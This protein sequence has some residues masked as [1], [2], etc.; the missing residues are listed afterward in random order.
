MQRTNKRHLVCLPIL[1]WD[2]SKT[3]S[4]DSKRTKIVSKEEAADEDMAN[5]YAVSEGR[6]ALD[7]VSSTSP[8]SSQQSVAT[9]LKLSLIHI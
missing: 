3:G 2:S 8:D 4:P 1:T 6:S 5:S 7:H 9:V